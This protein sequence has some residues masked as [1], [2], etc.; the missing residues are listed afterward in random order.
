[1]PEQLALRYSPAWHASTA[2]P[3]VLEE[4]KRIVAVIG[5]KE[6]AYDLDT[7]PSH[8]SHALAERERKHLQAEWLVY[9]VTRD[10][11]TQLLQALADLAACDVKRR[12]PLTDA[13]RGRRYDA[14]LDTLD[15]DLA[16]LVRKRAGF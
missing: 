3:L 7:T 15:P 4:V 8:L 5:L 10:P 12:E 13:E 2:W 6:A 14:A 9:F 16:A 1:M 11:T